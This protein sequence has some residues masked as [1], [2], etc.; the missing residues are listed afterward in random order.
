MDK[1]T[2]CATIYKGKNF[3]KHLRNDTSIFSAEAWVI[4]MALDFISESRNNKFIIFS[5]SLSVLESLENRK[6]HHPLIR[7]LCKLKNLSNDDDIQICWVPSYAGICGNDQVDKAARSTINLTTEKKFKI[8]HTDFKMKINKYIHQRQQCWNNNEN[9]K[10]LEIKP[11][12]G[13]WKQSF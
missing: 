4:N 8:P 7:I 10:S 12:L 11:T 13:K 3:K 2:G 1:I 5:D 6:F 9:N